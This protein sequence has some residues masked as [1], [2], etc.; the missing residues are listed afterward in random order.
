[1]KVCSGRRGDRGSVDGFDI[2]PVADQL[3]DPEP[4]DREAPD[5]PDDR[6]GGLEP[7]RE[8]ADQEVACGRKLGVG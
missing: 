6:S 8:D 3:L 7:E 2:R 1:M 4:V 5:R